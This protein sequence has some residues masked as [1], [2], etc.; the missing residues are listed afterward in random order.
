MQ[1][2]AVVW[3]QADHQQ[4]AALLHL[5]RG[6]LH[7]GTP[8]AALALEQAAALGTLLLIATIKGIL[9][10][11]E[12]FVIH[13][14][15]SVIKSSLI[16]VERKTKQCRVECKIKQLQLPSFVLYITTKYLE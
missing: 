1:G 9:Y 13:E 15:S 11:S 14:T 4:Q 2:I 6:L 7:E 5:L 16:R 10:C 8:F 12:M 3:L